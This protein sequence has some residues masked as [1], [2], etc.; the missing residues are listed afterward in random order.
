[1][2][3]MKKIIFCLFTLLILIITTGF[4]NLTTSITSLDDNF[5][6]VKEESNES[7]MDLELDT[8]DYIELT[9]EQLDTATTTMDRLH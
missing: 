1:M 5:L 9:Q 3:Y 4:S 2:V 6:F 8:E 7:I